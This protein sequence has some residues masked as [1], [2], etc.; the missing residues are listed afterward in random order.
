MNTIKVI[1][2]DDH[3]IIRDGIFTTLLSDSAIQVIG[4]AGDGD[5]LFELLKNSTPQIILMDIALPGKTGLELAA[6]LSA[7]HPEIKILI[8]SSYAD[9]ETLRQAF[10]AGVKGFIPKDAPK[11][12]ISQAIHSLAQGIDFIS[13]T[14]PGHVMLDVLRADNDSKSDK[15]QLL[16]PRENEILILIAEG[17]PQK[18]IATKLFISARTVET[19][20]A[21]IQHKLNLESTADIIKFAIKNKMIKL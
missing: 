7:S 13:H 10:H 8:F 9:T 4:E 16:T 18:E 17:M 11:D 6:E 2:V 3:P 20:K 21:N 19:H 5:A 14:I 12:E 15:Q 1:I